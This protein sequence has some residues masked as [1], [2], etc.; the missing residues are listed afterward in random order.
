MTETETR[1]REYEAELVVESVEHVATDTVVLTLVHPDGIALPNWTPGAHVDLELT[2]ALIRQYS[3]CGSPADAH[4]LQVGVLKDVEGRGGSVFIHENLTAGSTVL[5]RGPRNHFPLVASP[6]Y[7]FIAG[8]IGITPMLPMIA[9]AEAVGAEWQLVY[10]GR[11]RASMAFADQLAEHGDKVL[12]LARDEV[13]R[14][15]SQRIDELLGTPQPGTL[16]YCCGPEALL[17]AVESACASW[18]AGSLHVER[19]HA[20]EIE[21]AVDTE[22]EVVLARSGLTITVPAD[23]SIFRAAEDAGVPVLGSCHEGICGTCETVILEGEADHRD[24]VLSDS[25]KESN[26]TLMVCVSRCRGDRLV[27]DL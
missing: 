19:F 9:E 1:L 18:P 22:F 15:L 24:S 5:V 6:R 27:I 25:E 4:H 7:L 12:L 13:D 20:K 17:G 16:V 3:L 21:G 23:R 10:G 26:E 8:G 2:P 14:T 11:S